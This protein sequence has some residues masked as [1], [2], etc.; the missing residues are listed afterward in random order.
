MLK[1]GALTT[2]QIVLLIIL[3]ASFVVILYFFMGADLGGESEREIC[4]NSVVMKSHSALSGDTDLNCNRKYICITADGTCEGLNKAEKKEVENVRQIYSILSDEMVNC[5]WMFGEGKIDYIGG[6]LLKKNYCS[7]CS[8]VLF[9]DSLTS[10]ENIENG[11][12]SKD[13]LYEYMSNKTMNPS[14]EDKKTY[15]EYLLGTNNLTSLKREMVSHGNYSFDKEP[16][17]GTIH[18]G[19]QYYVVMG[20]TSEISMAWKIAGASAIV[21]G[22]VFSGGTLGVV[23]VGGGAAAIG[24]GEVAKEI[25]PEILTLT[26]KGDGIDNEFMVPTIVETQPEK[27]DRLNCK[28]IVTYA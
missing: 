1:K 21:L 6:K 13:K 3:I 26:R 22:T 5:W 17:F 7:I 10:L 24:G 8:Q 18:T 19:R 25:D 12:I 15:A 2:Q 20:I 9:D 28:E 11:K 23:L 16:S 4:H 27:F 14:E